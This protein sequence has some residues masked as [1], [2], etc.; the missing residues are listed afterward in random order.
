MTSLSTPAFTEI[1]SLLVA[2]SDVS[3]PVAWLNSF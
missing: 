1:K 3:T 2:K